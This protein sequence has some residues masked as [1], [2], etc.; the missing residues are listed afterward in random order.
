MLLSWTSPVLSLKRT[1]H[2]QKIRRNHLHATHCCCQSTDNGGD[3]IESAHTEQQVLEETSAEYHLLPQG[4]KGQ[5]MLEQFDNKHCQLLLIN[6]VS[7][8]WVELI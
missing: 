7:N 3:D 2:L 1:H 4:H 6:R 8:H 5:E